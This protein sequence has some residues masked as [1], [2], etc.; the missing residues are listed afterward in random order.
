MTDTVQLP[1]VILAWLSAPAF[2]P[3]DAEA[4]LASAI[5]GAGKSSRLYRELVYKQQIAQSAEC[6]NQSESLASTFQCELIAKPG[7]TPEK[8]EAEAE[9]IIDGLNSRVP[10]REKSSGRGTR[11]DPDDLRLAAGGGFG[12][13]ADTLNYYNQYTGD[14]GYLPKD[15]ARY[16]AVTPASV[17]AWAQATL[18]KDQRVVV[19]G[20]PGKKVLDDVPRSPEDTDANVKMTPQH[21]P[22][23]RRLRRGVRRRPSRAAAAAGAA[24]ADGIQ[25]ENGLTVILLNATNCRLSVQLQTLAG[26]WA[27]PADRPGLAGITAALL[28][29]GTDKR[30]AEEIADGAALL[31]SDLRRA[32]APMTR[33]WVFRYCRR[34]LA[35]MELIA[36]SPEHPSF[37]RRILSAFA[38]A[39]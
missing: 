5:L 31:G 1:K 18:G 27:D 12:G 9:K 30:S 35:G 11:G 3:G 36:D 19:Y 24:Q 28:T 7:V 2:K 38:R 39:A 14:P 25:L 4:D 15:L 21:T 33:R 13:V 22:S 37:R 20:V 32:A 34:S 16:D 26:A 8:L 17:Q 10:R 23:L 29:E 6:Y